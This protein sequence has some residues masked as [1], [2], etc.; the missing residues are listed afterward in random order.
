MFLIL[1]RSPY[2]G[3][4]VNNNQ[5]TGLWYVERSAGGVQNRFSPR[6]RTAAPRAG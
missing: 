2:Y 1:I 5:K 4:I 3:F 6:M